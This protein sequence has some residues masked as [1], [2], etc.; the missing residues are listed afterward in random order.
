M[1]RLFGRRLVSSSSS[2]LPG[3]DTSGEPCTMKQRKHRPASASSWEELLSGVK[4]GKSGNECAVH[5]PLLILLILAQAQRGGPNRFCFEDLARPLDEAIHR[6]GT[7]AQPGGSEM[8]FWHLK[9]D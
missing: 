5:K 2:P 3:G 6:F 9:N 8:P 1:N 4:L 7:A